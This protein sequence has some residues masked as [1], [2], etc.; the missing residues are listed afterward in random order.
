MAKVTKDLQI[1]I[2]SDLAERHG[3][4]PG[5]DVEWREGAN[6]LHLFSASARTALPV[7]MRLDL[8]DRATERQASRDRERPRRVAD[9]PRGRGW[10]REQ[11]YHD[12]GR[13][14]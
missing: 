1:T 2:P 10:T 12:R 8:F 6:G 5:D 13:T 3:I 9:A 7:A 4:K 11:L 14:R